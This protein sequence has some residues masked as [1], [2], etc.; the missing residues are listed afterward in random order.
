MSVEKVFDQLEEKMKK[1][2]ESLTFMNNTEVVAGV[3][4]DK[5]NRSASIS[6]AA[7]AC[8]HDKGSL[9]QGIPERPIFQPAIQNALS[10]IKTSLRAAS[11]SAAEGEKDQAKNHLEEAGI[12]AMNALKNQF[13]N[14][15]WT[16]NT[17]ETIK[18][19]KN[20][21]SSDQTLVDTGQLRNSMSYAVRDKNGR[22]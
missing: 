3:P 21:V 20:D 1:L 6:N 8:I 17:P 19:K 13:Q 15:H 10:D 12:T 16:A 14:N 5:S 2:Q 11:Q 9:L 7:L 4:E 18:R 22:N